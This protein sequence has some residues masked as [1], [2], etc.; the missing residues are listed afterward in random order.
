LQGKYLQKCSLGGLGP[1]FAPASGRGVSGGDVLFLQAVLCPL[2]WNGA[3][4]HLTQNNNSGATTVMVYE[5]WAEGWAPAVLHGPP[6][7]KDNTSED[8]HKIRSFML[9]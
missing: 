3:G 5:A 2:C 9:L 4:L 1:V 8:L 7:P 6:E